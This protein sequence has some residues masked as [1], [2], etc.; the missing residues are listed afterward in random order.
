MAHLDSFAL[1]LRFSG[2]AVNEHGLDLYDGAH[3]FQGF[4]QALQ[5]ATHAYMTGEIVSRATA[6]NGA[7]MYVKSP[8]N[9]SVLFDLV[10]L[11]EKYPITATLSGAAFY[12]FLKFSL[13][14][15]AGLLKTKPETTAVDKLLQKDDLFFDQL[16]ETLEG[17]L[18]RAHRAIDHGVEKVTLERPRSELVTFDRHT[19]EWV[20]TRDE[21]PAVE[22]FTGNIT[23]YNSISGNAR[24]YVRELGKILPVRPAVHFE[25]SKKGL[26]TW[27]L[28]GNTIA[29]RKELVFTASRI[30]S[31]RGDAKRLILTDVQQA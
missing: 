26:L 8:R 9:G 25:E 1:K 16:A 22:Q 2:K 19:S 21:N 4:A 11:V 15:A 29:A 20:H 30:D 24:A 13:S 28:H 27:S 6:L 14:K 31:A 3:S 18:Q 12:D 17:S 5:I 23:R 7:R 10:T